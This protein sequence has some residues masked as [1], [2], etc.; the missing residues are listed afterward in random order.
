MK[1]LSKLALLAMILYCCSCENKELLTEKPKASDSYHDNSVSDIVIDNSKG[2][3]ATQNARFSKCN[4]T[5]FIEN[6]T[7]D[8]TGVNE[9]TYIQN[10]FNIWASHTDINFTRVY[11][12]TGADIKLQFTNISPSASYPFYDC[13]GPL[14]YIALALLG[15]NTIY[16]NDNMVFGNNPPL[17]NSSCHIFDLTTIAAHEIGHILGLG[18]YGASASSSTATLM[19]AGYSITHQ[20]LNPD[21]INAIQNLY[22]HGIQ[23]QDVICYNPNKSLPYSYPSPNISSLINWTASSGLQITSTSTDSKS[24]MLKGLTHGI[25]QLCANASGCSECKTIVVT[26]LSVAPSTI[27]FERAG[28]GSV[29]SD[30]FRAIVSPYPGATQYQWSTNNFSTFTTTT[31]P[32]T[33][34][35]FSIGSITLKV[36]AITP[37]GTSAVRTTTANLTHQSNCPW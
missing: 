6:G 36:R 4:I 22:P 13:S 32:S 27:M 33:A 16:F 12:A 28:G 9:D 29:C 26:N 18:H 23:G 31:L 35:D 3:R 20:F 21:D 14:H 11:S 37:C 30:D 24:I 5:Y 15:N 17:G 34:Y 10:A 1:F 7:N 25:H 8:I 19:Q 2:L